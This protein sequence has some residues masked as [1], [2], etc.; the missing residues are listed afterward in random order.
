MVSISFHSAKICQYKNHQKPLTPKKEGPTEVRV[1]SAR[2]LAAVGPKS[3]L[4][5]TK[6]HHRFVSCSAQKLKGG[7]SRGST[8]THTMWLLHRGAI[9]SLGIRHV[10]VDEQ[11][12]D[13]LILRAAMAHRGTNRTRVRE[14]HAHPSSEELH[15]DLR[16]SHNHV[17]GH[18]LFCECWYWCLLRYVLLLSLVGCRSRS[19]EDGDIIGLYSCQERFVKPK[20]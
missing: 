9:R 12:M 7:A 11:R 10:E 8:L 13:P 4:E 3:P 18:V 16:W 19:P 15:M 5:N 14:R 1:R 2:S 6:F 20:I 17:V